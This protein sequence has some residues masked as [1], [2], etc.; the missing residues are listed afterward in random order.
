MLLEAQGKGVLPEEF[1]SGDISVLYKK[2][3]P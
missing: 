3:D 1:A 2:G